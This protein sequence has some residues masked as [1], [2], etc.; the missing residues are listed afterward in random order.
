LLEK[1]DQAAQG[2]VF[3]P[4]T[5]RLLHVSSYEG[6]RADHVPLIAAADFN[7]FNE[8]QTMY[9]TND[10]GGCCHRRSIAQNFTASLRS[11]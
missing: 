8:S 5:L 3:D 7:L 1:I 6:L 4:E 2:S 11:H 9:F 10:T